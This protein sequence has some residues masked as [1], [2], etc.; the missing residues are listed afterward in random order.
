LLEERADTSRGSGFGASIDVRHELGAEFDVS[1]E[2]LCR[3]SVAD[4]QPHANRLQL[5]VAEDPHAADALDGRERAEQGVNRRGL[6]VSFG[7]RLRGWRAAIPIGARVVSARSSRGRS[8][9]GASV[10]IDPTCSQPIEESLPFLWRQALKAFG[11][12]PASATVAEPPS[13]CCFTFRDVS[14]TLAIV[15]VRSASKSPLFSVAGI[16]APGSRLWWPGRGCV[17]TGRR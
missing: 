11:Q 9:R 8:G 7:Q 14:G 17:L 13:A 4:A 3:L 15:T 1:F 16:R 10:R 12:S 5:L 2:E 6:R